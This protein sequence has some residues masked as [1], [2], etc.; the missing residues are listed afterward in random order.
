MVK[1]IPSG[2]R[3]AS[4]RGCLLS[5]LFLAVVLYYGVNIGEVFWRYGQFKEEMRSQARLAP[6]IENSVI[7]RR[8]VAKA[9]E[10][11][12]P[13]EARDISIRRLATTRK[14]VIE[15]E[16]QESVDLPFFNHTFTL[17]P[18]AEAPL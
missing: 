11:S 16:Y 4:S 1:L 5:L 3:G 8:I 15:A 2:R 18:R 7:R 14:I 13:E 17:K 6:S 9:D 10:L 12:L